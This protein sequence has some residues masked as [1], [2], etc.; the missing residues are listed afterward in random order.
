MRAL[1]LIRRLNAI[2]ILRFEHSIKT[3]CRVLDVKR[4]SY[5]KHF[6]ETSSPRSEHNKLLCSQILDIYS[7]TKKLLGAYIITKRLQVEYQQ[8]VSV[9]RA[10]RLMHSMTLP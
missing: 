2:H 4:S 9:G 1:W 6:K 7:A 5:Y 8:F 10:Y 3:P